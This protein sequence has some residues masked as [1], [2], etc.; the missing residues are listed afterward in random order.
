MVSSEQCLPLYNLLRSL[1]RVGARQGFPLD[2]TSHTR[3]VVAT[4]RLASV[5]GGAA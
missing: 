3:V 5:F 4:R 2:P 1:Y